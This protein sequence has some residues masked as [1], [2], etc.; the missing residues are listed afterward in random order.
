MAAW[1]FETSSFRGGIRCRTS[2]SAYV[3][4][5]SRRNFLRG[6]LRSHHERLDKSSFTPSILTPQSV[7]GIKDEPAKAREE[8]LATRGRNLMAGNEG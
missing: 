8:P 7:V 3:R 4:S 6:F 5:L 1:C 2:T